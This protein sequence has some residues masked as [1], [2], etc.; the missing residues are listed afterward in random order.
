MRLLPIVLLASIAAGVADARAAAARPAYETSVVGLTVS[1]QDWDQDRPWVKRV[2]QVRL[3]LGV[4]VEGPRI[5][6][7]AQMVAD[8][9]LIEVEKFGQVVRSTARVVQS[10]PEV[11]LALLEVEDPGF[12]GDLEPSRLAPQVPTDGSV[13]SV[14]WRSRQLEVSSSRVS[15]IEVQS[16]VLG[17]LEYPFLYV[18]TDLKGGG[19]SEPVF[20]DG[21]LVG[22][23]VSQ[24]DQVARVLPADVIAQFLAMGKRPGP[25]PGFAG[26][27]FRWQVNEDSALTSYLGLPGSPR[28]VLVTK[29]AWGGSG[30][31]ALRERDILLSLD[32]KAIDGSGYYRHPR[33]GLL[34]FTYIPVEGHRAGDV[35]PAE[36]WRDGHRQTVPM[37]LRPARS[38]ADLMPDRRA[39]VAPPYLIAGGLVFRE[40]DGAY[41]RSWGDD[42]RKQAP[43]RLQMWVW[44]FADDQA[45]TRRRVVLLSAV[46]PDAYN[47]GYHDI[48]DSIVSE[49]NGRPVGS[50]SQVA[51]AFR[52]PE[53]DYQRIVLEPNGQRT[54]IILDARTF[55]AASASIL[56]SYHIGER[57]RLEDPFPDLGP[58]CDDRRR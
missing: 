35:I 38:D 28:G 51:E 4:V 30:C 36:V 49:I 54:E 41:L 10:D 22:L 12:F 9:T 50:I 31:G 33:Y 23:T 37:T 45:P 6:T 5:L 47:V 56:E 11:D 24:D 2:P 19:W 18:T 20:A 17:T 42:W 14:R 34:R 7:T 15:R 48:G 46:L 3:A 40:L 25:Y 43:I 8:A 21:R 57:Q 44:L 55:E 32:G 26:L 13:L 53:G 29:V 39:D 27:G 52:H 58:A 16:S 1:F